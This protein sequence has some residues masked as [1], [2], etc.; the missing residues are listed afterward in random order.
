MSSAGPSPAI[1]PHLVDGRNMALFAMRKIVPTF[2]Y[3]F[4]GVINSVVDH[5]H[6]YM[7]NQGSS[8]CFPLYLKPTQRRLGATSNREH[9]FQ[10]RFCD[11]LSKTLGAATTVD[12]LPVGLTP[13]DIF[14]YAYA[15]FHSPS[16][17]GRYAE[18]LKIDF[19]RLPLTGNLELFRALARLGGELTA[20]HLLKSPKLAQ[21]V[22]EFVGGRGPEVEKISWLRD[23]VWVDK[24][25]TSGFRGVRE[26]VWN[27]QIGGYQVC[28]K[29]L[30]DRKGRTLSKDD[31]AHY[32]KIV[33][34]LSETIRLM[35]EIDVV[36][37]KHGGWPGAFTTKPI[38]S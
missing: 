19:P 9:N 27:F 22:T 37:D 32:E 13:E 21:P 15:V 14:H 17:R 36:I 18:F 24:A 4:F 7:G 12:G 5:G 3:S 31:I 8:S 11:Q 23:T 33:V 6:F 30:K 1:M 34:A 25:Q 29:W 10:S 35:Q 26:D 20:L 28:N 16:Y 38:A 2:A